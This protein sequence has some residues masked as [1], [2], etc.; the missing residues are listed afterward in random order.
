[1]EL[2]PFGI[3]ATTV[4]PGDTKTSFT[5]NRRTNLAGDEVYKD[6]IERSIAR[7]EGRAVRKDGYRGP[8]DL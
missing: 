3:K 6:R 4:L 2:K 8:R 1:M 7:M 5:A